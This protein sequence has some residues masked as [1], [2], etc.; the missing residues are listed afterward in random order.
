M[1][2]TCVVATLLLW[3]MGPAGGG[4]SVRG[5]DGSVLVE[6]VSVTVVAQ[7]FRSYFV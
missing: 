5:S 7:V 1:R 2:F 3:L 4:E 6:V